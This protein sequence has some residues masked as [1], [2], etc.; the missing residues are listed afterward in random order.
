MLNLQIELPSINTAPFLFGDVVSARHKVGTFAEFISSV[1]PRIVFYP[2]IEQL[3]AVLQRVADGEIDRLMVFMP[4][5]HGKSETVSRLF[6]AYY[7]LRNPDKWVGLNSYSSELAYTLSRNARANYTDGGGRLNTEAHAVRHWETS[8]GGGLWA[9]G[10]GGPITGKGADLAIIDDPLKNAEEAASETI[11]AKQKDWYRSTLYT[12]LEPGAAV[13]VIQT[14]WHEDD[15]SGW[16]LSQE[17]ADDE[18][19]EQWHIVSM[20]ALA[21]AQRASFPPTCTVEPDKRHAGEA[22]C[23]ERY[24]VERLRSIEARTGSYFWNALFQQRPAPREGGMFKRPWFNIVEALPANSHMVRYWDKAGTQDGG[25]YTAGVLLA[26]SPDNR[27]VVMD[28]IRGQWS[29]GERE[30]TLE[31]VSQLDRQKYPM[32]PYSI[33]IEQEPGSGGKESAEATIK[34]LAGFNVHKEAVTG[35]KE[36]RA[37]PLAA[38]AEVGNVSLL[39]GAWNEAFL[40]EMTSFPHGKYKDQVDAASGAFNKLAERSQSFAVRY[41]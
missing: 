20:P 34:R 33:W 39:A 30:A 19:P 5:R 23:A 10:V 16:L 36:L 41:R 8:E 4:P 37:E 26:R 9:A 15:L 31:Q 6:V 17:M 38:Q 12:R 35:S 24:S 2:H 13:V 11:R 32:N 7:L 29:A 40:T 22:L 28:V 21:E 18:E 25:A 3:V 14:R 1:N 27:F